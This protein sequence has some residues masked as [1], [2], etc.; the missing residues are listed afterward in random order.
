MNKYFVLLLL[1]SPHAIS[2]L[3]PRAVNPR[4]EWH[5]VNSTLRVEFDVEMVDIPDGQ[6]NESK[7]GNMTVPQWT[8]YALRSNTIYGFQV[9]PRCVSF[10]CT[11]PSLS[12]GESWKAAVQVT[13]SSY[14][15]TLATTKDDTSYCIE[16]GFAASTVSNGQWNTNRA[17]AD[18]VCVT[19][20]PPG[21]ACN[22]VS[23]SLNIG[24]GAIIADGGVSIAGAPLSV[25]CTGAANVKISSPG[26]DRVTLTN[27]LTS[28]LTANGTP[29]GQQIVLA[30]GVNSIMIQ[31]NI[32]VPVGTP[33]GEFSGSTIITVDYV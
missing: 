16:A 30:S 11:D 9:M 23:P 3:Y 14:S 31:S 32:A 22:V 13:P 6:Y 10:V 27:G 12:K 24:H 28:T 17:S 2:A 15:F 29:L 26:G 21:V 8:L 25:S 1:V 33:V 4:A 18:R 5:V 20:P 19:T 7:G